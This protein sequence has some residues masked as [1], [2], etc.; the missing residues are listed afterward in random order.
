M[1]YEEGQL[2]SSDKLWD[3]KQC[4][5]EGDCCTGANSST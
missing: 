3:G 5:D 4:A 1:A 2:Y